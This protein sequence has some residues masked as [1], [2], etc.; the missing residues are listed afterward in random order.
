MRRKVLIPAVVAAVVVIGIAAVIVAQNASPGSSDEQITF[1]TAKAAVRDLVRTESLNGVIA[2]RDIRDLSS[3]QTG[4][5]TRLPDA[6]DDLHSGEVLMAINEQPVVLLNGPVPAWRDLKAGV[7]DGADIQQLEASL[8]ALGYGQQG[9]GY[10]DTHWDA[11]TTDAVKQFQAKVGAVNDGVLSLGEVV[12]T[13]GDVH[14]S[15]V[16]N[17]VGGLAT[18]DSSVLTVSSTERVVSLDLDP[19]DRD[20]IDEG[21]PVEVE[22]PSGEKAPGKV[23]SVSTTLETNADN[24][25]V[26]KVRVVLDDPAKAGDLALAPVTVHYAATVATQVLSV[27]VTA[28]IGVPGGGYAVDVVNP[29]SSKKRLPVQLGAWGDGYVQVTGDLKAGDTVEVPK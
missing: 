10:P 5:I 11:K 9:S 22:L 14:V 1:G 19:L 26:F 2:Y 17:H 3:A 23:D 28:I 20:L 21:V 27:P 12:F 8:L 18:P 25:Q 13:A 6:G 24:K 29:G 16:N 7:A 4:I 15:K